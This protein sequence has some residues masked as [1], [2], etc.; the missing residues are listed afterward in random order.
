MTAVS[1]PRDLFATLILVILIIGS[2]VAQAQAAPQDQIRS[3][4]SESAGDL[5]DWIQAVS[6]AVSAIVA[7][8]L[9]LQL[10]LLKKQ[11]A[12]GAEHL[13]QAKQ[14][15]ES[16]VQW[17]RL[18]AAFTYFNSDMVLQKERV[19][20]KSLAGIGFD[21]YNSQEPLE[22]GHVEQIN[23]SVDVFADVKDFLNLIEDY[24]TAVRIGA[25]DD[26]AA[27]A[28]MSGM[29]I[30]W[31]IILKPFIDY[32]RHALGDQ[33]A[34][35]ELE[36]LAEAWRIKDQENCRKREAELAEAQRRIESQRGVQR[37]VPGA[38]V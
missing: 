36:K 16:G 13:K 38:G 28:M 17:N 14:E 3:A 6:S 25:I 29:V 9:I 33:E 19:A 21:F 7:I 5:P 30:R 4:Q 11:L 37:K 18:N 22:P 26:D 34:F 12:L 27:Y 32:R 8:V 1:K 23:S 2:G 24:C 15:L 31:A 20:A 10:S 35:C